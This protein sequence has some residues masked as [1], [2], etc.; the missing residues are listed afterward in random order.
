MARTR[1][2]DEMGYYLHA[3]ARSRIF[4]FV[5]DVEFALVPEQKTVHVRSAS[6]TGSGDLGVKST[7]GG[8]SPRPAPGRRHPG[9]RL[10]A[11]HKPHSFSRAGDLSCRAILSKERPESSWVGGR[12][13]IHGGDGP[14]LDCRGRPC[15]TRRRRHG[16]ACASRTGA[17]PRGSRAARLGPDGF[18]RVGGGI[19]AILAVLDGRGRMRSTLPRTGFGG[20]TARR[21]SPGCR[22]ARSSERW[23]GSSSGYPASSS[24]PSWAPPWAN[25]RFGE[26][27]SK[28]GALA[29]VPGSAWWSGTAAKLAF[30]FAMLGRLRGGLSV[31]RGPS[32][33]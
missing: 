13:P 4:R 14:H 22:G 11:T 25:I 18:V 6:R 15:C 3:E 27:S 33:K 9:D 16:A 23:S 7:T 19:I 2:V 28:P 17:H 5:D 1:I 30:V 20:E 31:L 10:R 26:T 29:W 32:R 8:T 12:I 21:Q 24:V